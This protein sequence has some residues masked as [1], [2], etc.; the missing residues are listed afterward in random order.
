MEECSHLDVHFLFYVKRIE[1]VSRS[2]RRVK[3][4]LN[5]V[6][7]ADSDSDSRIY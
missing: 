4:T 1:I 7:V 6:Q 2:V 3:T 5:G